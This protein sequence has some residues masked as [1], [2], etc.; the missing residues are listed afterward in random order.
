MSTNFMFWILLCY[1]KCVRCIITFNILIN[2]H[3]IMCV[4]IGFNKGILS[5]SKI[6][7]GNRK[8]L[9]HRK[10]CLS[11]HSNGFLLFA[12]DC[13]YTDTTDIL[14]KRCLNLTE[15]HGL[16]FGLP[17]KPSINHFAKYCLSCWND[18][19]LNCYQN[20]III[21]DQIRPESITHD[22]SNY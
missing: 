14:T 10:R 12:N 13:F 8:I 20:V 19:S 22:C 4:S 16:L 1:L 15:V 18:N 5:A 11:I 2:Q 21:G 3:V 7:K 9:F 17:T 6:T